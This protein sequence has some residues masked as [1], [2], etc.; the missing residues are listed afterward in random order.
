MELCQTVCPDTEEEAQKPM[1][2]LISNTLKPHFGMSCS[3]L[4]CGRTVSEVTAQS[5]PTF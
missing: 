2:V 3:V 1:M 4:L 5:E